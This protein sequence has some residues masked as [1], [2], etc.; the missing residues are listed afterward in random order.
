[1]SR[2]SVTW[3]F[4]KSVVYVSI[5]TIIYYVEMLM[6]RHIQTSA[7]PAGSRQR[8][9]SLVELI[10]VITIIGILSAL[11]LTLPNGIRDGSTDQ[12]RSDDVT[13]IARQLEVGYDNQVLGA[14]AYPSTQEMLV[15]IT[16][17]NG[18]MQ[19]IEAEVLKAP[20]TTDS[21]S[22]RIATSNSTTAP[23]TGGVT[24]TIYVYQPLT[25]SGSL[26]TANPSI[27]SLSTTCVKFNFYYYSKVD[28]GV[29][30]ITSIRQQ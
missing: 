27:T 18:V 30:K 11:F 12:E 20:N 5:C 8:G 3:V 14:P 6:L 10:A 21:S 1:M 15:S 13:S 9:Y 29:R 4:N 25:R 19:G 17:K 2:K 16:N 23:I 22:V 7:A 24:A 26:C 28:E